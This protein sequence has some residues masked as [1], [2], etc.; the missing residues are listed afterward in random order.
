MEITMEISEQDKSTAR[1]IIEKIDS[2]AVIDVESFKRH[3]EL[4]EDL[5]KLFG[6][7][8]N[9]V[10]NRNRME[11]EYQYSKFDRKRG[12]TLWTNPNI[13]ILNTAMH[14]FR[15]I[16]WCI[17]PDWPALDERYKYETYVTRLVDVVENLLVGKDVTEVM[18]PTKWGKDRKYSCTIDDQ[19]G[20][21]IITKSF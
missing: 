6:E 9:G 20:M 4:I 15:E 12:V 11:Y 16:V 2:L 14:D 21:W 17:I 8:V 3:Q 18:L 13:A 19:S 7:Y 10:Y 5:R 1:L